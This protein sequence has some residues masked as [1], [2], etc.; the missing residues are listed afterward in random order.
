M[1]SKRFSRGYRQLDSDSRLDSPTARGNVFVQP[2]LPLLIAATLV[3][4]AGALVGMCCADA[5]ADVC[6]QALW[7]EA[8]YEYA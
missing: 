1:A 2:R 5:R 8:L 4:A 6:C 3:F 7:G